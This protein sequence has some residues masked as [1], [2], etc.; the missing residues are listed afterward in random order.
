M[1]K[2]ILLIGLG[3]LIS[4]AKQPDNV[5]FPV[6][7]RDSIVYMQNKVDTIKPIY[8]LD[9][10]NYVTKTNQYRSTDNLIVLMS[11][12]GQITDKIKSVDEVK[13]DWEAKDGELL[14]VITIKNL[15]LK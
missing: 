3:L 11:G 6:Q 4:C 8:G 14:P 7:M 2:F 5:P 10:L 1:K 12:I 9:A 13:L 15:K